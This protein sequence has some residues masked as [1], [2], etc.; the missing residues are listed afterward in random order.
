M[1]QATIRLPITKWAYADSETP[2]GVIDISQETSVTMN[3]FYGSTNNWHGSLLYIGIT[4]FPAALDKQRIY[5]ATVKYAFRRAYAYAADFRLWQCDDDFDPETLEWFNR[6]ALKSI[7]MPKTSVS[8]RDA[9]QDCTMQPNSSSS[10]E[11]NSKETSAML[12]CPTGVLTNVEGDSH[13]WGF[14]YAKLYT[15]TDDETVPYIEVTYDDAVTIPSKI[16]VSSAPTSGYV[17]PRESTSFSWTYIKDNNT[18][19]DCVGEEYAQSSATFYWKESGAESYTSISISGDQKYI[20]I[21]ANTFPTASAVEWYV[22]GTDDGGTTTTIPE[23]GVYSFSTAAGA[24]A[25]TPISPKSTV[26]SN[27]AEITFNW[28][29]S[30]ADG[31]A[32]SRYILQWKKTTDVAWTT[33]T[34]SQTVVTSYTV[35]ANTFPAGEIQWRVIP[36]NIDGN[37]GTGQT[38]SF[39]CY[40]APAAPV[41]Y[42]T[43]TPFLTVTWQAEDQQAYEIRIDNKTYGPY[44]GTDKSFEVPDRLED[45]QHRVE[46]RIIGT[47]L[48]WSEWGSITV[49]IANDPGETITLS[50]QGGIDNVLT[51]ETEE[52]TADFLVFRDD[53][54][55]GHTERFT[56]EDR[57]ALGRHEYYVINK[58]P[59]GNYTKSNTVSLLAEIDGTYIASLDGGNWLR[60]KYTL[61]DSSDF[62]FDKTRNSYYNHLAGN[63]FPTAILSPY[64]ET[65]FSYS[66]VFLYTDT[67]DH[68]MFRAL[69]G[70]RVILKLK[71]GTVYY[72]VLDSVSKVVRKEYYTAY[73][74]TIRRIEWEDFADDTGNP[75]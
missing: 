48:L 37:E 8:S 39:I 32:P 42:S 50:G 71:D 22:E 43:G 61:T 20:T 11:R 19:Y 33:I 54:Q 63:T 16:T 58:L 27:N 7:Y 23:S 60:I 18:I 53:E 6:P 34:D 36:Y 40:G 35:A 57:I 45:G 29:Y 17:N 10:A 49:S 68:E 66:A 59:D 69:F 26:E 55:I 2:I 70:K 47:Y 74:F 25:A 73:T 64:Q 75:L 28:S 12:R 65:N 13:N 44:F 72:G 38:T 62:S 1:A 30:S 9:F 31:F 24:V 51:W 21:P 67:E 46:V 5:Y 56:F 14:A 3:Y 15:L 41:V 52:A 4:Q